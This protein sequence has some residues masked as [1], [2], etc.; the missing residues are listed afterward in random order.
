MKEKMEKRL[1]SKIFNCNLL[2]A[3]LLLGIFITNVLISFQTGL[4]RHPDENVHLLAVQYYEK[5]NLPP[6]FTDDKIDKTYSVHG[7]SRLTRIRCLL[8]FSWKI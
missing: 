5:N 8:F 3:I 6:K 2:L 4:G 1:I 7:E